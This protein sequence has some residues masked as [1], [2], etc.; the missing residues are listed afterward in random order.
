MDKNK[1]LLCCVTEI[2]TVLR[3]TI[4]QLKYLKFKKI[5]ITISTK[6]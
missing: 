1:D 4:L 2:N 5:L 3:S 6:L